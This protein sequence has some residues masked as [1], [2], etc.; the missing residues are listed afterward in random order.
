MEQRAEASCSSQTE[1][2]TAA[3]DG[4]GQSAPKVHCIRC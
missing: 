4:G 3:G 1:G 2:G